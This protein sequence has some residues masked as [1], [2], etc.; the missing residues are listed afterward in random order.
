MVWSFGLSFHKWSGLGAADFIGFDNYTLL[1]RDGMFLDAFWNTFFYWFFSL[2][3]II[4]LSFVLASLLAY[5]GLVKKQYIQIALFIPHI[6]ATVAAGLV[7][8]I[9]FDDRGFVNKV[10]SLFSIAPQPWL[11][12]TSLSKLPILLLI[13]WRNVPWYMMIIYSGLLGVSREILEAALIDGAG[14]LRRFLYIIIPSVAPILF[15]CAVTLS[16]DSWRIF[17]EPYV[18]TKGGPGSSS[19]SLVQYMFE[20]GFKIFKMGYAS[21]IGYALTAVLLLVSLVQ[22]RL[23]KKQSGGIW[24]AA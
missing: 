8:S 14:V 20:N 2:L 4:P 3:L 17:T 19:L 6:T 21:T 24:R 10:L 16:I 7:F 15:F 12:S 11:T 22:A 1:L 9:L 23:L 5:G 13:I 18:L